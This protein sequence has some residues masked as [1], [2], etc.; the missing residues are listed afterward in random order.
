MNDFLILITH[1]LQMLLGRDGQLYVIDPLN[2]NSPSSE[3]LSYFS[4][5]EREENIENLREWR[6]T[7]LSVLEE[8]NQN[9]GM[10]A[11]FVS[12]EMLGDDPKFEQSLLEKAR[13][14]QDLIIMSYDLAKD[15]TQV[16]Y[17]PN[18]SYKIDRIE[19]MVNEKQYHHRANYKLF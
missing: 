11:I 12:K 7:S 17:E 3:S 10:N 13:K 8:F 6:D 14:Q 1:D 2:I 9:K 4:Q 18:T 19:V 16:L 5:E 15:T